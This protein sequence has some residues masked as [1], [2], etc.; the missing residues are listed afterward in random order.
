M[1]Q[2]FMELGAVICTPRNPLCSICPI[3]TTCQARRLNKIESLPL[4]KPR[5]NP[6]KSG[7]G[8]RKWLLKII[9]Y[10]SPKNHSCPFFKKNNGFFREP[11][12][13]LKKPPEK[14][15]FRHSIT[16]YNIFVIPKRIKTTAGFQKKKHEMAK[17]ESNS[18]SF[19]LFPHSENSS[20]LPQPFSLI[21]HIHNFDDRIEILKSF[22][23][24]E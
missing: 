14:Y 3:H 5:K 20:L 15:T 13:V 19:S 18:E 24:L 21:V 6:N 23:I 16:H 12:N 2:A 11:F 9:K 1:N 7:F 10:C 8:N 4:K 17:E 22:E